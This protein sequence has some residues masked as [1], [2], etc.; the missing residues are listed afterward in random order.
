MTKGT[1]NSIT[2]THNQAQCLT[3]NILRA[4]AIICLVSFLFIFVY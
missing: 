4:L 1:G 3:V 2:D